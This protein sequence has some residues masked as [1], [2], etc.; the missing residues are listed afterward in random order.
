MSHSL[1]PSEHASDQTAE[2]TGVTDPVP[3]VVI[4]R[5]KELTFVFRS[6]LRYSIPS[7]MAGATACKTQYSMYG[8]YLFIT[9]RQ[10]STG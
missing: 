3:R 1:S 5:G 6:L 7:R 9:G 4:G 8:S 10:L 2:S